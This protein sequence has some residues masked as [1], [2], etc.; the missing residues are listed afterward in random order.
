MQN[1][2]AS[3]PDFALDAHAPAVRRENV[4]NQTQSQSVAAN[5]RRLRLFAA[6]E[7]LKDALL[8]GRRDAQPAIRNSDLN[9]F[10]GGRPY[11]FGA[12]P[13]PSASAV[14]FHRVAEQVLNRAAQD[15]KS[16]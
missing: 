9:L 6:I 14:V 16:T 13:D 11:Q 3:L 15:R 10:A 5:L 7:R 1:E 4:F 2:H 8:L 12:Q